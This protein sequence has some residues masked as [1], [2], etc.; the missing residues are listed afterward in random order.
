MQGSHG[1]ILSI[2]GPLNDISPSTST[3]SCLHMPR[4][5]SFAPWFLLFHLPHVLLFSSAVSSRKTSLFKH[6]PAILTFSFNLWTGMRIQ[7]QEVSCL[8]TNRP[9]CHHSCRVI[10]H[11]AWRW[12]NFSSLLQDNH[13][14]VMCRRQV[15]SHLLQLCGWMNEAQRT[16]AN[17][18]SY[19]LLVKDWRHVVVKNIHVTLSCGKLEEKA[20]L[21]FYEQKEQ[22]NNQSQRKCCNRWP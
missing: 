5:L 7:V 11:S 13:V 3:L 4:L 14:F 2:P 22:T 18:C 16:S 17:Y 1:E 21:S 8:Q 9:A 6:S 19:K 15:S 12:S 10:R 20:F